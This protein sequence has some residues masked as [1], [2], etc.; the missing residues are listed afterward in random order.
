MSQSRVITANFSA[1]PALRASLPG[2]EGL[3]P[4]GFRLTLLSYPQ[5]A[6]QIL[7]STNLNNWD[8]L[9]TVT[10]TSGEVQFTDPAALG[11]SYRFYK[12]APAP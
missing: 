2:V 5:Q 10:N 12:A 3:T 11:R 9:G 6:W 4:E 8:L 7:G 1:H